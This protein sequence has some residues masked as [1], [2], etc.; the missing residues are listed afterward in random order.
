MKTQSANP[1]DL[2]RAADY[3]D[4]QIKDYWVD[5]HGPGGLVSLIEP[6]GKTTKL[7][8]GGKGSGKTHL[9]RYCSFPVQR[10]RSTSN[11]L[12]TIKEE[13]YVGIFMRTTILETGRFQGKG[14][15]AEQWAALFNYYFEI[16]LSE[17]LLATLVR[18]S[19]DCPEEAENLDRAACQVA[20][21]FDGREPVTLTS[22]GELQALLA[23]L[24]KGIDFA[25]NNCAFT[26]KLDV[27]ILSTPGALLFGIPELLVQVV[28][29][30]A[31]IQ[32]LY[33]IDEAENLSAEQQQFLNT[34]IRH[35]RDPCSFRVGARLYG[36]KTYKTFGA[37]EEN[38]EG[39]EFKQ[40]FLDQIMRQRNDV[41][42]YADFARRLCAKRLMEVGLGADGLSEV[43]TARRL[44]T[45]FDKLVS[46]SFYQAVTL[47]LVKGAVGTDRPYLK[48]LADEL[49]T[50]ANGQEFGISSRREVDDV[51]ENLRCDKFPLI[52]KLNVFMLYQDWYKRE[53]LLE[54]SIRIG[55]EGQDFSRKQPNCERHDRVHGH[56]SL[57]LLAQLFRDYKQAPTLMYCGLDAFVRLSGGV[58]R[59]LL[60]ILSKVYKWAIFNGEQP[61]T[62]TPIRKETQREALKESAVFFYEE[63]ARPGP[64]VPD[65]QFAIDRLA[66]YFRELRYSSKPVESSPLAFSV[67]ANTISKE[68][69]SCLKS[70]ENWSY[71]FRI[72]RGRPNANSEHMDD[73]YQ[74]NP[75]LS[76]KWDLPISR[77]GDVRLS[78]DLANAIFSAEPDFDFGTFLE[79][80]TR[81]LKAP[82]FGRGA[83]Q[84]RKSAT[85]PSSTLFD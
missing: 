7:I 70:A 79:L 2:T 1:F 51:I 76:P 24:R 53:N 60:I 35:R 63:D 17:E 52:E 42:G 57:D 81:S 27:V 5:F 34:L 59:N 23:R 85:L 62:G 18:I 20:D 16:R 22:I 45:Y 44:D 26:R 83:G 43:E 84:R 11:L 68:A 9:M 33:L 69:R 82:Q 56:F 25:V 6:R 77:R 13:G 39:S 50:V 8:L 49:I 74:L 29:R 66:Q 28:P 40:E 38:K 14:Q 48:R 36:I 65:A 64:D 15:T 54:A 31:D 73:K 78:T 32:V 75:M 58:P 41:T 3:S 71:I 47:E 46:D 21:L 10:L 37:E 55:R 19:R 72:Q 80:A 4:E 61:F 67:N 30:F 12:A